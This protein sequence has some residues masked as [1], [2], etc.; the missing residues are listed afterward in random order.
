MERLSAI[1]KLAE[2]A[3]VPEEAAKQWIVKQALWQIYLLAPSY[4]PRPKFKVS[5]PNAFHQ[6]DLLFLPHEKLPRGRKVC[7]YAMTVVDVG[8]CYIE[9]EPLTSKDFA[10]VAKAFQSIYKRSPLTSPPILQ[11]DPGREFMQSL[12][13]E[14]ENQKIYMEM[15]LPSG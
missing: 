4:I 2:S 10:K 9:A 13:K 1:R 5:T 7:K 15:L 6:E 14:M 12:T 8:S 11:V 3:K